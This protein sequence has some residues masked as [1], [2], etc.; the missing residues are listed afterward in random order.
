[1]TSQLYYTLLDEGESEVIEPILSPQSVTAWETALQEAIDVQGPRVVADWQTFKATDRW[2]NSAASGINMYDGV[3]SFMQHYFYKNCQDANDLSYAHATANFYWRWMEKGGLEATNPGNA[4]RP[5]PTIFYPCGMT[6]LYK[7]D[8]A[9]NG[10]PSDPGLWNSGQATNIPEFFN[11]LVER[12]LWGETAFPSPSHD[13]ENLSREIAGTVMFYL[14][15]LRVGN[16]LPTTSRFDQLVVNMKNHMDQWINAGPRNAGVTTLEYS[17]KYNRDNTLGS[18]NPAV[19]NLSTWMMAFTAE[20]MIRTYVEHPSYQNDRSLIEPMYQLGDWLLQFGREPERTGTYWSR[21]TD[22]ADANDPI[23]IAAGSPASA[24]C[25]DN[26]KAWHVH[27]P[28]SQNPLPAGDK[29]YEI[30]TA[31][32]WGPLVWLAEVDGNWRWWRELDEVFSLLI[33]NYGMSQIM[34]FGPGKQLNQSARWWFDVLRVRQNPAIYTTF[35]DNAL[36]CT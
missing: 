12:S 5:S 17:A 4:Y 10:G 36:P 30:L 32:V 1:M 20:A 34:Q 11:L 19:L 22:C 3:R 6:S 28:Y 15:S 8:P 13:V 24:V 23:V 14:D 7:L 26:A 21:Y 16:A 27:V 2:P 29:A 25:P 33:E 31:M 9:F 35:K 18:D